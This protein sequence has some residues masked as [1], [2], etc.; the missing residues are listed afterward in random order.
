MGSHTC[1]SLVLTCIDFRFQ[2]YINDWIGE[3]LEPKSF[4]RVAFAGAVYDQEMAFKQ[5]E[6]SH[7]LHQIKKAILINHEECGAYGSEGTPERH[8]KDLRALK[9]RLEE[10]IPGLEV[11]TFYLHLDGQF[12]KIN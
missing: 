7:R 10:S 12:E 6:V 9:K 2:E 4:D 5:V 3:N 11:E 1:N 8:A